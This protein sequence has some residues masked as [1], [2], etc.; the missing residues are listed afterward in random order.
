VRPALVSVALDDG[1]WVEAEVI[2]VA[3]DTSSRRW[4]ILVRWYDPGPPRSERDDWVMHDPALI[5]D[6]DT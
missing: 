1:T 3:K 6:L 5:R 2:A 4:R